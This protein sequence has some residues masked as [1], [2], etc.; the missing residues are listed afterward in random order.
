MFLF[1][2]AAFDLLPADGIMCGGIITKFDEFLIQ[3]G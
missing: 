3:L 1:H 2:I